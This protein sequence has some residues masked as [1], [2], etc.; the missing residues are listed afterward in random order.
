MTSIAPFGS[1][2]SPLTAALIAASDIALGWPAAAGG[3]LFWTEMRPLEAGRYVIVRR[4]PAGAIADVTPAGYNART[5]VH[6][7]GGGM[8]TLYDRAARRRPR[9][10][11]SASSTTSG[12]TGRTWTRRGGRRRAAARSR[13]SP[14]RRAP[15]LR[16]RPRDAR[17]A[18]AR[19][20]ARAP[21]RRTSVSTSWSPCRPTAR[22]RAASCSPPATT[23]TR[24]RASAPTAR[25]WPGSRWDH[26][27]MPWDG[28][29]LWVA[30]LTAAGGLAAERRVAGGPDES[31]LQPA[32]SPDGRLHFVSDRS[33][34]WNLYRAGRA[35][36]RGVGGSRSPPR[37]AEFAG[38]SWVFGLQ[39]YDFLPDGA[40]RRVL[41]A[42]TALDH[43]GA[44][45]R[46][47]RR[48]AATA[49][50]RRSASRAAAVPW[51]R[52]SRRS[53]PDGARRAASPC[54]AAAPRRSLTA[55]ARRSRRRRA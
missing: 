51:P 55:R 26:P 37:A 40:H 9:P 53:P 27:A 13:P 39:N 4:D 43:L 36:A 50:A 10:S 23:S 54:S 28:T 16:R 8:Y 21:R 19:L 3:Q 5:L 31:V 25:G 48:G 6:E 30:E 44:H 47:R 15:A 7:Y 14:P 18:R 24:R 41:D 32:W 49:A 29:E 46:A 34:W 42:R 22:R 45:R 20:R 33:G 2:R 12:C 52:P 17:R 38:P 11:S 1:W 35:T